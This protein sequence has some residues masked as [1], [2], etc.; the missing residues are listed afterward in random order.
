MWSH[1]WGRWGDIK[2]T[3][4][5]LYTEHFTRSLG[6]LC[7]FLT[8]VI[9]ILV[10]YLGSHWS[11]ADKHFTSRCKIWTEKYCLSKLKIVDFCS[12]FSKGVFFCG[13]YCRVPQLPGNSGD[14]KRFLSQPYTGLLPILKKSPEPPF[15]Y[16]HNIMQILR[17]WQDAYRGSQG[18]NEKMFA[19]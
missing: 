6:C 14:G 19:F 16:F 12:C 2:A 8:W 1:L 10:F 7:H 3:T 11:S 13:R 9:F 15:P 18:N 4:S 17:N 5:N